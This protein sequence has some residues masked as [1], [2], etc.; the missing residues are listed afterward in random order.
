M[1]ISEELLKSE[2]QYSA[3]LR[4][5]EECINQ[6]SQLSQQQKTV[7]TNGYPMLHELSQHLV[8]M[9]S[10]QLGKRAEEYACGE[11]FMQTRD[12]LSRTF[13]FYF[14]CVEEITQIVETPDRMVQNALNHCL[15]QMRDAGIF[16]KF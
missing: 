5:W 15:S 9:I 13:A 6:S 3:E 10:E 2:V 16:G 4:A 11:M 12:R 1:K 7:L 14:R 8:Q